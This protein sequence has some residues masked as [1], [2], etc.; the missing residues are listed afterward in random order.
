MGE[1]SG[2]SSRGFHHQS[3]GDPD[4]K[5]EV[6][7][8]WLTLQAISRPAAWA[9]IGPA[10]SAHHEEGGSRIYYLA[11]PALHACDRNILRISRHFHGANVKKAMMTNSAL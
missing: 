5:T 11:A 10:L 1:G 6:A 4:E 3:A 2:V 9:G 8:A 7:G